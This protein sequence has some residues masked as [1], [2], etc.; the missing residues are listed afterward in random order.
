MNPL[1]E[2]R[3]SLLLDEGSFCRQGPDHNSELVG[4]TGTIGGRRVCVIAINPGA[5]VPEDP[6]EILAQ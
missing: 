4:G 2:I 3:L 6:V 1:M 5:T